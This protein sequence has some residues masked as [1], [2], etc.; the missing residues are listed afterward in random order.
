M[1]LS[2]KLKNIRGK[3]LQIQI[4]ESIRELIINQYL[5]PGELLPSSRLLSEQLNVSRNTVILAYDR[6]IS[7]DY[8]YSKESVGTFVNAS[9]PEE[10]LTLKKYLEANVINDDEQS[11]F[12]PILF[13]GRVQA[14]NNPHKELLD[15]D[16][17]IGKPDYKSFPVSTWRKLMLNK[18]RSSGPDM[19]Q[20]HDPAGISE[21]REAI[22]NHI[23]PARGIDVDPGQIVIVNG[24]QE[25]LNVAARLLVQQGTKVVTE[26][27]CYQGAVFVLESYGA[28]IQPVKTDEN[29]IDV[30]Q[31]PKEKISLAY[32]TPSHQYPLG[33]TLTLNRRIKLLDWAKEVGA[34]IIEDDYDSDFR[35]HGSPLTALAGQD[36][37][38]C[39]IYMGTFSKSIGAGLRIGYMVVPHKMIEPAKTVKALIDNGHAWLDQAVLSD[40]ISSGLYAKHLRK[41]RRVYLSRRDCLIEEL[42]KYFGKVSLTGLEGGMHLA[43]HLPENL[44]EAKVI[45]Q[46]AERSGVG[47]YTLESGAAYDFGESSYSKNTLLFGYSSTTEDEIREGVSRIAKVLS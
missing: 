44:P 20:Y 12:H 38:G 5:K 25:A 7:E 39:V 2:I 26:C 9:L 17:W 4:F 42:G 28:E 3:S 10:S 21:L 34:Y 24:S 23:R 13:K 11:E 19:I 41:I 29:G 15:I 33:A 16:F 18:L 47:I 40:F 22:A 35:H 46:L 8:V 14:L 30:S 31:L 27:P 32:V 36:P 1:Q 43:W 6:L 45:K 37:H